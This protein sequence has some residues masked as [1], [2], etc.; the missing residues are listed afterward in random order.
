MYTHTHVFGSVSVPVD[1][2]FG[3]GKS[4]SFPKILYLGLCPQP[5]SEKKSPGSG[6]AIWGL[7]S[8]S[9]SN[10]IHLTLHIA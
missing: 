8:H 3:Y 5:T 7:C 2:P 10:Y 1:F 6:Q 9:Y 4:T